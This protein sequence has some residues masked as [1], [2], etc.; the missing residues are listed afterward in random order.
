MRLGKQI[1]NSAI[2]VMAVIAF[3]GCSKE[4]SAPGSKPSVTQAAA[5]TEP[6]VLTPFGMMPQSKV[7]FVGQ[8]YA[9]TVQGGRLQQIEKATGKTIQDFG[10]ATALDDNLNI[11]KQAL[12]AANSVLPAAAS[13]WIDYAYWA[14][15]TTKPITYFTTNWTV[16]AVPASQGSQTLFL[17]NGM[18]DGTTASSYI[19][20][21]V[22]QWG[23]SAAGGG[24][25]WAIT[26]WY[27]SSANAFFGSLVKVSTGTNLQGTM[28]QTGVTKGL[29]SYNSAFTGYPTTDLQVNNVPQAWWCAET[30]ETYGVTTVKTQ[31]PSNEFEAMSSI[32]IESGSTNK[33]IKWTAQNTNATFKAVVVSNAS[34]GGSVDLYFR[35]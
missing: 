16:P 4:N 3:G 35:K 20:Q 11:G 7:H 15:D 21:P 26:N 29:Y 34:P 5:A 33:T 10:A 25:Y 17:F 18:Q 8:D 23:S 9:I 6:S 32:Q 1:S 12:N 28:T 31:Y 14:N 27:V 2:A 22:L 19:V 13:G 24:K 30:L